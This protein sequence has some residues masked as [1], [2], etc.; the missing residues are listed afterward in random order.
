ML[1]INPKMLPRLAELE[2]DLEERRKRASAEGRI[3]EIESL[4]RTL[5]CLYENRAEARRMTRIT[6]QV[7]LGMPSLAIVR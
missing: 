3:G 6:R 4:D 7:E 2:T 5:Q 1:A